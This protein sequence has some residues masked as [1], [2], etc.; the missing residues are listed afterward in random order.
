M[1]CSALPALL[2]VVPLEWTGRERERPPVRLWGKIVSGALLVFAAVFAGVGLYVPE[3]RAACLAAAAICTAVALLG[4][5]LVVRAFMSFTG[6][7]DVLKH[8]LPETATITTIEPTG[9]R[10]NRYYPIVR[11]GVRMQSGAAVTIKQA[12]RP[13]VLAR[14]APGA[15]LNVRVAASD[16]RRVVIDWRELGEKA[17]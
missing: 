10:Y 16:R 15:I 14:L 1:T 8:G 3:A 9:W 11:F 4:V 5:P 7:E 12:V 2:S 13:D 17:D 6:D